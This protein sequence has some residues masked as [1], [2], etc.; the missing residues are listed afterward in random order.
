MTSFGGG[1][2]R[3]KSTWSTDGIAL[4]IDFGSGRVGLG[5]VGGSIGF[6]GDG[7]VW[8]TSALIEIGSLTGWTGT[9]KKKYLF[10]SSD[11]S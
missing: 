6:G 4:T 10:N 9:I 8:W 11:V 5:S 3:T 2:G 7:F 1:F